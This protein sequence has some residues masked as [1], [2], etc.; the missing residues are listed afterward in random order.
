VGLF[1]QQ[2]NQVDEQGRKQ[3][4]WK[5]YYESN[6][7]LF[8][9]GQFKDNKQ[10]GTFK[11]YYKNGKLRSV[12]I[13]RGDTARAEVFN[14][15]GRVIASGK[16]VNQK[17]DSI[18][19]Y[20]NNQGHLS[21]K[22]SYY[23]GVKTGREQTYY[24]TGQIASEITYINDIEN[25]EFEMYYVNGSIENK[26]E[27]LDGRYDGDFV[28]YYDNGKKMFEGE[29]VRGLKNGHWVYFYS[30]GKIKMFINYDMGKTI[31]E[32]YQNGEFIVYFDSGMPESIGN[33]K[34]GKK[35]GYFVEY[36]NNGTRELRPRKKD[37]PY[38]PDE[39]EEV[40]IGQQ[41]KTEKTY[42]N[43]KL[44]GDVL[45]YNEEGKLLKTESYKNGDLISK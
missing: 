20:Y 43:N 38:Q 6:K 34:D 36:F 37:D 25:G 40:I 31:N 19:D 16:F 35:N 4:A 9:E 29:Y 1:A 27:Y 28:Y 2:I 42:V 41:I 7:K 21:Q 18:W 3:G 11:H 39:M 17:K 10:V 30:N 44:E 13:Y 33:Y 24:A 12:T 45:Y 5:K 14:K 23:S 15:Q 26:G 32:D 22:E 8:Y